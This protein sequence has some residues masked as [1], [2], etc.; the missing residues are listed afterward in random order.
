MN[1]KNKINTFMCIPSIG[2]HDISDT[3]IETENDRQVIRT[4]YFEGS[5]AAGALYEFILITDSGE[6]DFTHSALVALDKET[7]SNYMFL[8]LSS[9]QYRMLVYDIEQNGTVWR[10]VQYPAATNEVIIRGNSP[11]TYT[12]IQAIIQRAERADS[13]G[14]AGGLG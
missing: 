14:M 1:S 11:G 5:N 8:S 3:E 13:L 7:S 10:G 2:T 9:G 4:E 12:K 6:V